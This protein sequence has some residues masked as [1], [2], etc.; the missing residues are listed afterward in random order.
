[1]YNVIKSP[2]LK[3]EDNNKE[4]SEVPEAYKVQEK[5]LSITEGVKDSQTC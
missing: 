3:L 2:K 5:N 1:M 4:V